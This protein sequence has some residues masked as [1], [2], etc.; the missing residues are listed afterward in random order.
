MVESPTKLDRFRYPGSA[1]CTSLIQLSTPESVVSLLAFRRTQ[2]FCV[3]SFCFIRML[4]GLS[5][6][7][8]QYFRGF[9]DR[10]FR[11]PGSASCTSLIQL[12]TPESV[13]SLLAFR[14]TQ[15]FCVLS[16]C[17][18]R[19]LRGLSQHP[20]QYFRGFIDRQFR[21]PGS[22]SC[23][24]LIQLSTPESVVS[25]L[26]FRRT[27]LF[28]VLSFCFI[29]M[30]R[31]LSQHPSQYFRGFIDRQFRYPGSASCTSLIQLSTPESVVSL[32]A[33]RRTQLFCV[34]SFCFIRMLRGLSQHPSQYF[35]GFIDRQFRY[36]GSASCTSLIQ[37]S[38]PESVVSLLA[39]RRTQLF[40]VLSFCFIRMLR[41][42][43]QHPSQYFRGF[44]DRHYSVEVSAELRKPGQGF[45]WGQKW[46]P[47]AGPAQGVG[48]GRDSLVHDDTSRISMSRH[49][50]AMFMRHLSSRYILLAK[51]TIL[52]LG[53]FRPL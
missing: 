34:L 9:I 8:S 19:M 49:K 50:K 5:Q 23:T 29:R 53:F 44:I 24:S 46:S 15:L 38:T 6:H 45:A 10:Q 3:L 52:I 28:C 33:F 37:L 11:Y 20:S 16:F 32:L 13:V 51:L 17:F 21:Y 12:S 27:Q 7:P 42:L 48:S 22:A 4:R 25:L 35:R 1:S 18:I 14:R 47:G 43:S 36:P 40:C 31:G 2:L 26:A 39:F 41:G 30:L